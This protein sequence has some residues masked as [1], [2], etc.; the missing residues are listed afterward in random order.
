MTWKNSRPIGVVVSIAGSVAKICAPQ[1]L[2]GSNEDLP[3]VVAQT[4]F[5]TEPARML[6]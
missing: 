5:A 3:V 4:I 1:A 6:S 2:V